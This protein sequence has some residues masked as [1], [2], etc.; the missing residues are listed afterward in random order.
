[1]VPED[2]LIDSGARTSARSV[3]LPIARDMLPDALTVFDFAEPGFVSGSRDATNVPSQALYLLNS[4]FIATAALKLA[5][6]VTA[7]YPSRSEGDAASILAQ[8]VQLAY[9]LAFSRAPSEP[10]RQEA[11]NF[12]SKFP[13]PSP[14]LGTESRTVSLNKIDPSTAAWTSFCRALF[15][16]AE[17]RYL[18]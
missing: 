11:Y 4:P 7:T 12:F 6:R 17:F 5:E 10:E 3:Y 9:G 15:A 8:R 18:N 13:S 2:V 1:G 16:C 14:P